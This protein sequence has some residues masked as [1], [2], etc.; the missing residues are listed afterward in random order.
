MLDDNCT[1][2][3]IPD[4]DE[5]KGLKLAGSAWQKLA[6]PVSAVDAVA[7][8]VATADEAAAR[9]RETNVRVRPAVIGF[10][11]T[12][13]KAP[14][15]TP[16]AFNHPA[17]HEWIG[18]RKVPSNVYKAFL[19][20]PGLTRGKDFIPGL[21]CAEDIDFLFRLG[22]AGGLVA[23]VNSPVRLHDPTGGARAKEPFPAL[24]DWRSWLLSWR[25][26]GQRVCPR[27]QWEE[28][29]L[30]DLYLWYIKLRAV[31]IAENK[32]L[33]PVEKCLA[34]LLEIDACGKALRSASASR[35]EKH[36]TF[37]DAASEA[38]IRLLEKLVVLVPKA[39]NQIQEEQLDK[40][41]NADFSAFKELL[42]RARETG[43][44]GDVL[45]ESLRLH[46][47]KVLER[48]WS[49]LNITSSTLAG[50]AATVR[51]GTGPEA[52]TRR[53]NPARLFGS[54]RP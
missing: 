17:G 4:K 44:D 25:F 50:Q 51:V 21:T 32:L 12:S 30:R 53:A 22:A 41:F 34:L 52:L 8:A 48:V 2:S 26:D 37:I 31:G 15:T 3:R 42:L 36:R 47:S 19:L 9:L 11:K 35:R 24:E 49:K 16:V 43:A 27:Q 40:R 6:K 38:Q 18:N 10:C 29:A 1:F 7:Q 39:K 23:K 20:R 46:D 5:S 33:K 13:Q 14:G 54:D 28:S 45:F